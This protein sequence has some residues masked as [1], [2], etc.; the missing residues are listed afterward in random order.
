MEVGSPE[1]IEASLAKLDTLERER[2]EHEAA[3]ESASDPLTL[4]QHNDALERLD[5]EIKSLYA[6]LESVAGE[7][8][9]QEDDDSD[10]EV[11]PRNT[12]GDDELS[13]P[14]VGPSLSPEPAPAPAPVA[15]PIAAAAESPFGGGGGFDAP[16]PVS[17]DDDLKPQGGGAKWMFVGVVVAA[18]IGVGGFFAYQNMQAQKQNQQAK[19]DTVEEIKVE[20]AQI[21]ED[22]EAPNAAKG[23]DATI[24]PTA[25]GYTSGSGGSGGGGGSSS[26]KGN[27][28]KKKKP[29]QL[30]VG[31]DPLG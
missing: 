29:L 5:T 10:A 8:E 4:K 19:P 20:A 3:L 27:D 21:P 18:G 24:S 13:S 28:E 7:E 15:T 26:K 12:Q 9:E 2:D 16:S 22:T 6:Q 25:N 17:F 1:W 30:K 11:V 14:H 23:G 31:D